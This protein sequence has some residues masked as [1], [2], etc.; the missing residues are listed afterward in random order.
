MSD[1]CGCGKT[2]DVQALQ[3]QQRRVLMIVLI[4]N[5]ATF[6]MMVAAA[7]YSHSS[8]LL[9]GALD[10]L[11]DALTY[12]LSLAVIAAS[13]LAKARVALFKGVL[14]LGAAAAVALQ[15]GWRLAHPSVPLFEGMGVAGVL[16]LGMNLICLRMLTPYRDGD[17]NLSSAWECARNDIYEGLAVIVAAALVW[18]FGAGWP[19]L[20]IAMAWLL[21]F[22]RSALRVLRGA[23]KELR[24]DVQAAE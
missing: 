22:L 4:I 5:A 12:A 23:W 15:I 21:L 7:L 6:V 2:I 1:C 10:N 9:S 8:S 19:D 13:P 11:G 24:P 20:L 17:I 14:I 16:N 3:A 18:L